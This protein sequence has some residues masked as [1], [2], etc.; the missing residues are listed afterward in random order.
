MPITG[1]KVH[2]RGVAWYINLEDDL[3]KIRRRIAGICIQFSIRQDELNGRLLIGVNGEMVTL[4]QTEGGTAIATPDVDR[5]IATALKHK[6]DYIA[7]DPLV[8]FHK[9]SEIANEQMA[10]VIRECARIAHMTNAESTFRR[11]PEGEGAGRLGPVAP[12]ILVTAGMEREV[13]EEAA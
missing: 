5:L 7:I 3:D 11:T 1:E 4:A 13:A 6:V 9:A 8:Q 12:A 2:Q 10:V